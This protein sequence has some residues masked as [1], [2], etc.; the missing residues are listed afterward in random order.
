MRHTTPEVALETLTDWMTASPV[1]RASAIDAAVER[2]RKL[3]GSIHAWVEVEP[4]ERIG[5]GVLSG[6]PFG[7]KD[8]IETRGLSTAYGS[9]IYQGRTG[10]FDAAIIRDLR[11]RGAIL[12]GKTVSTP[13]A[14][15][16]PGPTR[17]PRNLE[18]TP[19]GSSSG[20]AA[21]VAAGMVPFALGT[22]T[23]GSVLRPASFCGV[24]GFKP[25]HGV[26]P[27]DGVFPL[28]PRLDTLGLFT[29]T[30]ADMLTLWESLGH[31]S[32]SSDGEAVGIVDPLPDVE[33]PMADAFQHAV[34]ALRSAGWSLVA[35]DL[36]PMLAR[37]NAASRTVMF[38]EAARLHRDRYEE[39]GDRLH[40]LADVIREGLAMTDAMFVHALHEIDEC[41]DT[42]RE[43][44]ASAPVMLTPAAPGPPPRGLSSTG[45][46]RMNAPWTALGTPAISIPMIARDGLPLGLQLT[47]DRGQDAR[48]LRTAVRVSG[49]V[50]DEGMA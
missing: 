26:L 37:L 27:L 15:R 19:G 28:A 39:H 38:Y 41:R 8:V 10:E 40:G 5:V 30:P 31:S 24:T 20:S 48:V 36:S 50:A 35:I 45:D 17:N 34:S 29:H 7:A 9:E 33:R 49:L 4:Q 32:S 22:Q 11:E 16:T 47:A 44:F 6:I 14:Y 13:F 2:I 3:D 12:L 43:L 1:D 23:L 46:P 21:A 18:H 42:M 25:T